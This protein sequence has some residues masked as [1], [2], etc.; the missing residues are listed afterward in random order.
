MSYTKQSVLYSTLFHLLILLVLFLITFNHEPRLSREF[1]EILAFEMQELPRPE[2]LASVRPPAGAGRPEQVEP[3]IAP[4]QQIDI[5]EVSVPFEEP[6]DI[7]ALPQR[8]DRNVV[9]PI[10][11]A[12]VQDTLMRAALPP[13]T[14]SDNQPIT[15]S[16]IGVQGQRVGLEGFADEIRGQLEG[17]LR[18]GI[19]L[20]GDVVNRLIVRHV[21][22]EFPM[23]VGDNVTGRVTVQFTVV[24]NGS[25]H[26]IV[27]VR[28]DRAEFN[29]VA[30]EALRQWEF[31]R[32]DRSHTGQITFN[33]RRE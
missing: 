20:E 23:G 24:E 13:S 9:S 31:N 4:A 1:I 29:N 27:P 12:T 8:A 6:F 11:R 2:Q 26:N 7:S 3:V 25:V 14:V 21:R 17:L 30:I 5:P 10:H 28:M 32:S 19:E 18:D 22:P 16:G 15:T 33:F